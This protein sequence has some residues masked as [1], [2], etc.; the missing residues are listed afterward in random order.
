MHQIVF[1]IRALFSKRQIHM[2][3]HDPN[4]RMQT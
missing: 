2:P 3:F 1:I 4:L